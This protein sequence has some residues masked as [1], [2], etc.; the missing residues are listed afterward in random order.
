MPETPVFAPAQSGL[1]R[2]TSVNQEKPSWHLHGQISDIRAIASSRMQHSKVREIEASN[3]WIPQ[4]AS[5]GYYSLF[6][7]WD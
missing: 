5:R 4:A 6:K 2:P 7:N 1:F 3:P